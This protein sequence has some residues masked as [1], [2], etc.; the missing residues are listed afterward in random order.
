M[1][2]SYPLIYRQI[3]KSRLIEPS[4]LSSVYEELKERLSGLEELETNGPL[5]P[6]ASEVSVE[7]AA[8]T[9]NDE[10]DFELGNPENGAMVSNLADYTAD[11][12]EESAS[13]EII[14]IRQSPL[15]EELER[16]LP[17]ELELRELL[18]HWQVT[19][20]LQSR[21]RFHLGPYRIV[22]SLGSGGYGHV[23]LARTELDPSNKGRL[24]SGCKR[25]HDYAVKVLPGK[26]AR[27]ATIAKF[28][29]E[30]NINRELSHPNLVRLIEASEDGNV[31][32]AVYEYMDGGD[33]RQLDSRVLATDYRVAAYVV[34]ET[35]KGLLYLHHKGV[36]HRDIKPGNILLSTTGEV[37]LADMGLAIPLPNGLSSIV[38][39][40]TF[41][42]TYAAEVFPD[43]RSGKRKI[44]GTSDYLSPDQIL[45]P[46]E[47]S[48]FWDIYSLGCTFYFLVTGIVPF[49]SGDTQQKIHAH[50]KSDAPDPRM[51]NTQ[52]PSELARLIAEMMDKSPGN[53]PDGA[54]ALLKRLKPFLAS[55]RE[56]ADFFAR[57]RS[58]SDLRTKPEAVTQVSL[59]DIL[60]D[61]QQA[62]F[63]SPTA[64]AEPVTA[65]PSEPS[66]P[67]VLSTAAWPDDSSNAQAEDKSADPKN[68]DLENA[69][70]ENAD[71]EYADRFLER[72]NTV[73][74]WFVLLP[75]SLLGLVLFILFLLKP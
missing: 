62:A 23:F 58:V 63:R 28:R 6:A 50:L 70:L 15:L 71:P 18:N 57:I 33:A 2:S 61:P 10:T 20:I 44:E 12:T 14:V 16:M 8:A 38:L 42:A 9:E 21:T 60:D 40:D 29:R 67:P 13:R 26:E 56:A 31:N 46:D 24:E 7:S 11:S 30:V 22:D 1:N 17:A 59:D 69:D 25:T 19:Q 34:H 32:Y 65:Q 73:L 36:V 41:P 74:V 45:R 4:T 68:A 48:I 52:L 55:R 72:L 66:A 43:G 35:A 3:E 49:P 75:L 54:S 37:K 51:F 53:R 5:V 27:S 39:P 64:A 47:P